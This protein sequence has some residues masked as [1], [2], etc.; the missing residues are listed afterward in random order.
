MDSQDP[1]VTSGFVAGTIALVRPTLMAHGTPAQ[2]ERYL[3]PLL[4]GDEVWCQLFSEPGAGSDLAALG[5][6]AVRDGD[7]W[8]VNGQKVWTSGAQHAD[9]AILI[10]RTDP[11]VPKHRGITYFVLDMRSPG[12][13]VRPLRQ[14]DGAAECNEV[15]LTDVSVPHA[16]VVGDVNGGWAVVHTTLASE[17]TMIGSSGGT[18]DDVDALVCLARETDVGSDPLI[19][20]RIADVYI[21]AR[22][23]RFLGARAGIDGSVLKLL[24]AE[25]GARAAEI[26]VAAQGPLGML[27]EDAP[28]DGYWQRQLLRQFH[29][30]IGGGTEE[31]HRNMIGERTLGLPAEPRVDK[32]VPFRE[33]VQSG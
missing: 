27:F 21:R 28:E 32:N 5:T 4:R 13:E 9:F 1:S 10:A 25:A 6:R 16:N 23:L 26:G 8:V 20:Q 24:W 11:D 14:I 2:Q 17:S 29:W 18:D 15:F 30:R 22:V 12:V 19:R 3:P 31:I 7:E 33:L